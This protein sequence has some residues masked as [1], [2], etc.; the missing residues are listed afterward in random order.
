[1]I[2]LSITLPLI[3]LILSNTFVFAERKGSVTCHSG[4]RIPGSY[5]GSIDGDLGDGGFQVFVDDEVVSL[6]KINI[7]SSAPHKLKLERLKRDFMGVYIRAS[8][9]SSIDAARVLTE[10][11]CDDTGD[12][13]G[14]PSWYVGSS[15]ISCP[16][17]VSGLT[18]TDSNDKTDIIALLDMSSL[19][20]AIIDVEITAMTSNVRRYFYSNVQ[21]Q[22]EAGTS[23]TNSTNITDPCLVNRTGVSSSAS[24]SQISA[25]TLFLGG[26]FLVMGLTL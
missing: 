17:G 13:K 18:Q 23:T 25:S 26:S 15:K 10:S 12:V 11:A 22:V 2:I 1:M 5:H 6:D 8:G 19:E 24:M 9:S 3:F 14:G 21:F 4:S 16:S 20:G 7:I